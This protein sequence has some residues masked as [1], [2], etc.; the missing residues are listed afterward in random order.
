M[1]PPVTHVPEEVRSVRKIWRS[2]LLSQNVTIIEVRP[3]KMD[4]RIPW[5]RRGAAFAGIKHAVEPEG[6]CPAP[7]VFS[8]S[9]EIQVAVVGVRGSETLIKACKRSTTV[10]L[11][12]P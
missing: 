10:G 2:K 4:T 11:E 6:A 7:I 3:D 12:A 5:Q 8:L 1:P 9:H